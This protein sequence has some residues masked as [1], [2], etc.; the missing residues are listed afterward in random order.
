MDD[1]DERAV[2]KKDGYTRPV[3]ER[4]LLRNTLAAAIRATIKEKP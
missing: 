1:N 4:T 2:H 3:A